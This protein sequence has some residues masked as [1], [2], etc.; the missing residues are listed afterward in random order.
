MIRNTEE[1]C[2]KSGMPLLHAHCFQRVAD[3]TN[4]MIASRSVGKFATGLILENYA[5]KGF[6][7]K[8]KS[9]NWG[10]MAGFVCSDPRFSKEGIKGVEAQRKRTQKALYYKRRSGLV[11]ETPIIISN[12]RVR[13]LERLGCMHRIGGG[14]DAML[15]GATPKDGGGKDSGKPMKFVLER[16]IN[17]YPPGFVSAETEMWAVKYARDQ[18]AMP[19]SIFAPV[20]ATDF[21][22]LLSVMALVDPLCDQSVQ[23]THRKALTGDYDLWGIWPLASQYKPRS[24]DSRRV[25]H[26]NHWALPIKEF[27]KHE[28]AHLGNITARGVEIRDKLN[29]AI[30]GAGYRGGN[31]VHHSDETGRP[32]VS[33]VEMEFIAFLPGEPGKARFI[34]D[35]NDFR[36]FL[37][38][39][40]RTYSIA[41]N[42]YWQGALGFGASM[43]I[44]GRANTGHYTWDN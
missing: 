7:V 37:R 31:M 4:C 11:K 43:P 26:S 10:P 3:D 20:K 44:P 25:P 38:E 8:T 40:W 29:G 6:H 5:S 41:L 35:M 22:P 12:K 2:V 30:K 13:E 39:S 36:A 27:I 24:K 9:C 15:Y 16:L 1:A 21:G 18:R 28:D 19:S 42:G 23:W 32:N 33:E 34:E 17:M 14:S